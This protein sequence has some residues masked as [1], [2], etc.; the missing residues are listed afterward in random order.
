[1]FIPPSGECHGSLFSP[2]GPLRTGR[3]L[4]VFFP[5]SLCDR[6]AQSRFSPICAFFWPRPDV[7]AFETEVR[8]SPFSVSPPVHPNSKFSPDFFLRS[9]RFCCVMPRDF[10]WTLCP[11]LMSKLFPSSDVY[12]FSVLE[13]PTTP[14]LK[15]HVVHGPCW[16]AKTLFLPF[17]GLIPLQVP[18]PV[19]APPFFLTQSF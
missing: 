16:F 19:F 6:D 3:P 10:S 1:M 4:F 9:P 12:P 5:Q 8:G 15:T 2:P 7:S 17:A 11:F 18:Q 13:P 14:W